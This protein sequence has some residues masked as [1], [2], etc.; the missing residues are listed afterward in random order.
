MACYQSATFNTITCQW[1]VTGTQPTQPTLACYQSATFNN[2][3]CQWDVTGTQPT[4]PTL[5]CYQ[6]ATFNTTTCHWDVTGNPPAAIVT[7][8][9]SCDTYTWSANST[10]YTQS[11]TYSYNA[12]CQD[13][14]LN[15]TINNSSTSTTNI[16]VCA[17]QTPYQWNGGNYN[18]SG[19]YSYTTTNSVGCDSVATLVLT[20]VA[21][22]A[23]PVAVVTQPTCS[24]ATGTITVTSPNS[25][26]LQFSVGGSYQS[27]AVFSGLAA[28]TYS[29]VAK[30]TSGCFSPTASISVNTQPVVPGT[31]TIT[32]QVNVCNVIGTNNTITY[33]ANAAG[34]TTYN[35]VMPAN[36]ILV[37]GQGTSTITVQFLSGFAAQSYKQ[38]RVTASSSCGSNSLKIF[39]VAAQ[40]PTTPSTIVASSNFICPVIGTTTPFTYTIPKV[41][42]AANYIW[43]AQTGSTTISHPNGLG[44]NDTVI[45]VTFASNF[46]SSSITVQAVNSCGTSGSR[47]ILVSRN[48]PSTPGLISGPTNACAYIGNTGVNAVY[49]VAAASNVT[50]YNW[51]LPIGV[52][53][54]SGQG[55][56]VISFRYP[57]GFTGGSLSV[58]A[59]NGCGTSNA[60]SLSISRLVPSTPGNIDIIN[61][62]SCPNRVYSY[63]VASLPGNA[64]SL[65]WTIPSGG[66]II[67]GQGTISIT[68][69]YTSG[70]IDG[71]V[72]VRA[73]NNCGISSYKIA[74]VRLAPCPASPIMGNTTQT[75]ALFVNDAAQMEV[76]VFP[77]PTTSN[78]NLQVITADQQE[79]VV[80]ILDVQGR[81]IK[82]VKVAPYQTLNIG[83]DLK[84]GSYL[85]EVKQGNSVKT[86]RVVKY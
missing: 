49:S 73:I 64:T 59:T 81:L 8:T 32:G 68:V 77:N 66:T 39:Y 57:L 26:G 27:S 35:W 75:K 84:S 21:S 48:N 29:L 40:L 15:L 44:E 7:T 37:S 30:N 25:A 2:T 76:K 4:Q 10:A 22:I 23:T 43:S 78:F 14:A 31:T 38:I 65:E 61:L 53:N 80:R 74:N 58:T 47:S 82:S 12:N 41:S 6:S 55:T 50:S 19:S 56:N 33:T 1:D 71:A 3:T 70:L 13:Y 69:S 86:T 17:T 9:S 79:L 18:T 54:V 52:T 28:G 45:T 42:G 24:V 63:A 20:V 34:A 85:V 83:S 46:T 60:R 36:T 62:A 11:G 5:A 72:A 67:S 51:S 16:T